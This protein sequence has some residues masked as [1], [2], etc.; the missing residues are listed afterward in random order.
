MKQISAD[1]GICHFRIDTATRLTDFLS[2]LELEELNLSGT[3][4]LARDWISTGGVYVEGR[5]LTTDADLQP[6]HLVRLHTRRKRYPAAQLGGWRERVVFWHEDF[7]VL[8]KPSGLPT[9]PT[10]DNV[11]ENALRVLQNELSQPLYTTHRLDIPTA[12]LLILARTPKA[13]AGINR[14]FALGR[15][16]KIYHALASQPV[17]LGPHTHYINPETRVP[18][19]IGVTAEPG[20]WECRLEVQGR[21]PVPGGYRHQVRL[22]TGKTHQNR[23]QI[24][25]LGAPLNG[26]VTYGGPAGEFGLVCS[27]LTFSWRGV[28]H[29]CQRPEPPEVKL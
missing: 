22:L 10:L 11:E 21:Q 23:A 27:S 15:V 29:I 2:Q 7:L 19:A 12:G 6:G 1:T 13:Q 17:E 9:H 24:A 3:P 4:D 28:R 18:R 16:E 14:E 25:A 26:D 5:R 8:D 20:W